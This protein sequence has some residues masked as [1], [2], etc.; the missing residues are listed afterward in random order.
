MAKHNM[1]RMGEVI[2]NYT[3]VI[4][5]L[6]SHDKMDTQYGGIESF[7]TNTLGLNKQQ[8]K[9]TSAFSNKEEDYVTTGSFFSKTLDK[10]TTIL[11]TELDKEGFREHYK[12]M[13]SF[14]LQD[15]KLTEDEVET[16]KTSY[17][18]TYTE[19][20]DFKNCANC[21]KNIDSGNLCSD[22]DYEEGLNTDRLCDICNTNK[23][24]A[25]SDT[26]A[27]CIEEEE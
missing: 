26:C 25:G 24:S 21:D 4:V 10:L 18:N 7:M 17:Y 11:I 23:P 15:V 13:D 5:D 14:L 3:T 12:S 20:F 9:Y 1:K 6:I 16:Y 27:I 19:L 2:V 22:C 8:L